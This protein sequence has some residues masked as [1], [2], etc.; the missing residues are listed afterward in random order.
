[1]GILNG[2][3]GKI[4]SLSFFKDDSCLVSAATDGAIYVW[5]LSNFKREGEHI[6][7]G[8]GYMSAVP[9]EASVYAVGTDKMIKEIRESAVVREIESDVG[10]TQIVVSHSGK[11]MFVGKLYEASSAIHVGLTWS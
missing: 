1:M 6:L 4:K 10:L 5:S 8:C 11:M 2:H 7:K 3:N 9:L